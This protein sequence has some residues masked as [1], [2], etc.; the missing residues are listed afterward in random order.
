MYNNDT[1]SLAY[2]EKNTMHSV[3][4]RANDTIYLWLCDDN[5]AIET[6]EEE[7][8]NFESKKWYYLAFDS[9]NFKFEYRLWTS[10][11]PS[12][13]SNTFQQDKVKDQTYLQRV[14]DSFNQ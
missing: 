5:S 13:E 1:F 7:D 12:I 10:T 3:V 4:A 8:F 2:I 6:S 11:D 14:I 9:E